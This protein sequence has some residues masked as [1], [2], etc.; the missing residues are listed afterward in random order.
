MSKRYRNMMKSIAQDEEIIKSGTFAD[1][2]NLVKRY[3]CRGNVDSFIQEIF[4][5]DELANNVEVLELRLLNDKFH[6][7]K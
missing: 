4:T 3:M 1:K 2:V 6:G 7:S 5:E